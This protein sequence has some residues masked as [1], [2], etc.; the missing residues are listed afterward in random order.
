MP[1]ESPDATEVTEGPMADIDLALFAAPEPAVPTEVG[2]ARDEQVKVIGGLRIGIPLYNVYLNEADE[3][4]RRLATEI[5]E[6]A[7]EMN[8]R[9]PDSTVGLAHAL[10]GSSATVGFQALSDIARSLESALQHTQTLAYGTPQ[11]G[12]PS[13]N[14]AEEVRRLLH[15]FAAGFLKDAEPRVLKALHA[16]EG[17]RRRAAAR[18]PTCAS[19][20]PATCRPNSRRCRTPLRAPRSAARPPVRRLRALP[21]LRAVTATDARGPRVEGDEDIDVVDAIDPDLF[22]IFEEEAAELMPLLGGA[23]RLWAAKGQRGR[24]TGA[25]RAAH[26][27]GQRP[28]GRRAALGEL[29][30]RME[31]EVEACS[32]ETSA[33]DIE[34]AA[35]ALRHDA[36]AL[37]HAARH[38][39]LRPGRAPKP[40]AIAPLEAAPRCG[41]AARRRPPPRSPCATRA[42]QARPAR[43][44]RPASMVVPRAGRQPGRAR[45]LAAARP[46]GEPGRRGDDHPLAPRSRAAPAARLAGRPHRQPGP[47]AQPAARHRGAGR[48]ADAVAH[49]AGQGHRAGFDPLEFDRF[50]RVQELTRMMAESVNDVATVQRNIQRV[51]EATED[52]LIAQARQT[53]ELQRD[54]LRTRM[55]EFEGISD[56]LYRVVR[57]ASKE[58]G[59]QVKL[60]ITGGSIE[61]DRGVLDRMTPAFEHLL[62]NCVAHGVEEPD[63]RT[64]A[65]KDAAGTI[66]ITCA[67]KA[68]TSRWNSSDDGAGLNLARI[69]EKA[70]QQG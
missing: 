15:Q 12:R 46:P 36:G 52:D 63:V 33:A 26:A 49:G 61:M 45:A 69:R 48:V 42:A 29:A 16:A 2:P 30:H 24:A 47:P 44:A 1:I 13:P 28:P 20:R 58:S 54:L 35:A 64:A 70:L 23:L 40:P 55:V 38:R 67:R 27:Q 68:T 50:T 57:L 39:R 32:A 31:S 7:L 19:P 66:L 62:R 65:G 4:S 5:S 41:A 34:A 14:A 25:A 11:H 6:W 43:D 8:Q 9:V 10:A 3:W 59:K 18:A 53:R 21:P 37:R 22:P 56:R 51:V 60:D 17:R